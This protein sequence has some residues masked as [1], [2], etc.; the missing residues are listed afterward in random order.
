MI[1]DSSITWRN[2]NIYFI[3]CLNDFHIVLD[4]IF[5]PATLQ[6]RLPNNKHSDRIEGSHFLQSLE[7]IFFQ[8]LIYIEQKKPDVYMPLYTLQ[9]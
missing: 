6:C 1:Y 8:I 7:F 9:R 3:S 5:F 2:V 4:V